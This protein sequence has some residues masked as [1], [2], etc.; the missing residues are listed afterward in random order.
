MKTVNA[1]SAAYDIDPLFMERWSPR[2]YT[3][4][5]ITQDQLFT[6]F[7]A[8]RWA[9]SSYNSQPWRFVYALRDT[10][11]WESL[12]GLLNEFNQSWAKNAAA[13]VII[14]SK[15]TMQVPGSDA[16]VPSRS[17][18]FDA[19][20][21]WAQFAL[22]ATRLG[23]QAHGMVGVDFDA[24]A[25]KLKVPQDH[26]VEIAAVVGWPGDKSLLP[27]R[28]QAREQPSPRNEIESFALL[29]SFPG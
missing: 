29:G 16:P 5:P 27:E 12:F 20:A 3:G 7:E 15:K 8:A 25:S 1:R 11:Q 10:P 17:H 24:A 9:P 2:A 13:I 28:L 18:S 23:L 6:L 26:A 22:Q 19:G 4:A 21:A 14:C